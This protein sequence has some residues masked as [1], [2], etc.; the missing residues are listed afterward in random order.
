MPG[1]GASWLW[2][3][4]ERRDPS[5]RWI[6]GEITWKRKDPNCIRP[7]VGQCEGYE[8][9]FKYCIVPMGLEC[10]LSSCISDQVV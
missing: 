7:L 6:Q 8:L 10:S 9:C 4:D 3:G 1:R 2:P 5:L